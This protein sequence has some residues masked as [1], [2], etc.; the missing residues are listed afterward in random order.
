MTTVILESK[1]AVLEQRVRAEPE[2]ECSRLCC[3]CGACVGLGAWCVHTLEGALCT[4]GERCVCPGLACVLGSVHSVDTVWTPCLWGISR[5]LPRVLA[6]EGLC[7]LPGGDVP[8]RSMISQRC[9][10]AWGGPAIWVIGPRKISRVWA[11]VKGM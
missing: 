8:Q 11:W 3:V 7:A 4:S 2:C 1:S 5:V 9:L 10:R 6:E